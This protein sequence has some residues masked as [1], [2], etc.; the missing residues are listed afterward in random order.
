MSDITNP[1]APS[2]CTIEPYSLRDDAGTRLLRQVSSIEEHVFPKHESL[3]SDFEQELAR[4]NTQML[5]AIDG[6]AVAVR[7]VCQ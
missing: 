3:K 1:P 6:G 5:L 7:A 2:P 4:R